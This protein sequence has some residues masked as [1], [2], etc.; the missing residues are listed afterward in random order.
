VNGRKIKLLVEDDGYSPPKTNE[1]VRKLVEQDGVFA[2]V[3]G[4]GTAQHSAVFEYL[5][6]AQVP[7][8]YMATGATLFTDPITRTAFGFN[9]NY[10]QEGNGIGT[11]I[12]ENYPD[13]KVG[14]IIQ[15]DDFGKDGEKG[16][17]EG[18]EGSNVEVV[19]VQTYEAVSTDL[20]AQ[21]QRVQNDGADLV[22]VY[23]L[24]RQAASVMKVAREQLNWDAPIIFSGV[25]ADPTT[26]ALA[27]GAA[28]ADGAITTA[29][30]R[31][32]NQAEDPGIIKHQEIMAQYQPDATPSNLTLFGQSVA[33]MVVETLKAA[34]QNLNRRS[35]IEAAESIKDFTCSACLAPISLSPTD[36]RPI[37]AFSFARAEGDSWVIFGD[38]V[39]YESTP[40]DGAEPTDVGSGDE[41]EPTAT[42]E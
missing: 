6:D 40:G 38:L 20:T 13:A 30:L 18:I 23:S 7:D 10:I 2:I 28:N 37:E 21:V 19:S 22:A 12:V 29:Y 36:H 1:V 11:Y 9:P 26:I 31:P 41:A 25:V 3:G 34:G 33:E 5:A 14:L 16:I 15:N 24:P 27:G 8:L 17:R 32:L 39:S 35:V 42:A 4:L